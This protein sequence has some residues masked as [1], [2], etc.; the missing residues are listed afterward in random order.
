MAGLSVAASLYIF[1][2]G[3]GFL[4]NVIAMIF[5]VHQPQ[6]S[7]MPLTIYAISDTLSGSI[8]GLGLFCDG[9][10][11]FADVFYS[12][13]CYRLVESSESSLIIFI[14]NTIL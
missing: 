13:T 8:T 6:R 1:V 2:G 9:C 14:S 10:L 5:L 12:N 7:L 3:L 4:L 11:Y